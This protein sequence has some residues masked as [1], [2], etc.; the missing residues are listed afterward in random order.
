MMFLEELALFIG[1]WHPL[2]VHLPIGMLILAFAM[3]VVDRY[4]KQLEYFS[5]IRFT[6]LLGSVAAIVACI[7]GYFLSR[8]GGYE[9]DVLGYHKW[10]GV[11]VAVISVVT[12]LLY[13]AP[14]HAKIWIQVLRSQ[15]LMFLLIVVI[16]VGVAGHFGGTL[17]HGE[18]YMKDV[19]PTALKSTLGIA[20]PKEG[21][22][23][24]TNA[25]EAVVYQ[26][27]IQPILKQRCQS[28]HGEKK[29]EGGLALHNQQ[30]M[31]QGGDG[32][33][34]LV[35]G[36]TVKSE[37][38]A[39]L[40]LPE[41]HEKRMPPSGRSPITMDQIKLISW[42]IAAGADFERKG[43]ELPQS[44]EILTIL[45]K[46]E[47]GHQEET[48][49]Y[50]ALPAAPPLPKDKIQAWQARGI[51]IMSI[52]ADNNMVMVNAVNYA[53]FSNKDLEDLLAIKDNIVQLKIGRTAVTNAG[54]I[55]VAKFP[56]LHRLHLEYTAVTD[57][58]LLHLQRL[59]KVTYINLVG[60]KVTQQAL[61]HLQKIPTLTHLYA[62]NTQLRE[63]ETGEGNSKI[64]VDTGNYVLPYLPSDSVIF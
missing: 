59:K 15:R 2:L 21:V 9:A 43:K 16:L 60:T 24:L 17:T 55:T 62:F 8:N 11:A 47:N 53:Q 50:A 3:A 57:E 6:L 34:V 4:R 41:G 31:L 44:K 45:T 35:K 20:P 46:L 28:C 52:A 61:I 42:W 23:T 33:A 40:V 14:T 29:R 48:S 12:F 37:L 54:M 32:G 58:G 64:R 38:Y 39:R 19:L 22:F 27:I 10:L 26:D 63:T 13:R 1:R 7:T 56:V 51:K 36:D 18:G 30:A 5:A 25:Q 49:L